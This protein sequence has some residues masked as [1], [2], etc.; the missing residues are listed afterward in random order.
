M[1]VGFRVYLH[2]HAE[3]EDFREWMAG[4]RGVTVEGV[5]RPAAVNSQGSVWDFLS[6]AC[7]AG[8][9]VVAALRAVQLWIDARVTV[10]HIEVGGTRFEV[11][12]QD[13]AVLAEVM[14]AVRALEPALRDQDAQA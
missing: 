4:L 6:V 1:S 13:P 12:S 11:R 5:A 8:G 14:T 7:A 9:P 2:D 3:F 10:I